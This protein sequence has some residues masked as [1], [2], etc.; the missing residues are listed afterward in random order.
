MTTASW[1]DITTEQLN[2]Y[3]KASGTDIMLDGM[4]KQLG[5]SIQQQALMSGDT[6]PPDVLKA[7]TEVMVKEDLLSKFTDGLKALD[8]KDYKEIIKFYSTDLGKKGADIV[9]KLDMVKMQSELTSFATKVIPEDRKKLLTVLIAVSMS[10]EKQM[11]LTETM[12]MTTLDVMPKS[13]QAEMKKQL[14]AQLAE[15]KP[16][17]KEQTALMSAYM[18]RDY[19]NAELKKLAEHFKLSSTQAEIEAMIEGS[20]SYM[21]AA[22]PEII[23]VVSKAKSKNTK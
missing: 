1:A 3:M 2:I 14:T 16:M 12:M 9:R 4:Q 21:S 11:K 20:S 22:M 23:K 15:M 17:I 7:M 5:A 8:Q 6:I 18:Y 19:S 10:E 13:L